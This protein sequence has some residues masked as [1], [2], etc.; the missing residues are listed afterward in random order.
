MARI[1]CSVAVAGGGPFFGA[2]RRSGDR[3]EAARGGE[4]SRLGV[5]GRSEAA[6]WG[7][8]P[9]AEPGGESVSRI[10]ESLRAKHRGRSISTVFPRRASRGDREESRWSNVE[11]NTQRSISTQ[12]PSKMAQMW[13]DA[14]IGQD[15]GKNV[16]D[17]VRELRGRR[18]GA[19]EGVVLLV[20]ELEEPLA[21]EGAVAPIK[22]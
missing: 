2:L 9:L 12:A 1:C 18:D 5:F 10:S 14:I 19:H 17:R 22:P 7:R 16:L 8:A 13:K 15:V 4:G 3:S 21:V 6:L 20:E 11:S